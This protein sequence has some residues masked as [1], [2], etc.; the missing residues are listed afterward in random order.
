MNKPEALIQ[1]IE[2]LRSE[3]VDSQVETIRDSK[4]AVYIDE[5]A[6]CNDDGIILNGEECRLLFA[7]ENN[8]ERLIEA[9]SEP[10]CATLALFDVTLPSH[11]IDKLERR[12]TAVDEG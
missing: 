10:E 9:I 7:N 4:A 6:N 3:N 1:L 12:F 11:I 5:A 2:E 8:I